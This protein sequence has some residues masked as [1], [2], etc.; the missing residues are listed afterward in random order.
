[1]MFLWH[2]ISFIVRKRGGKGEETKYLLQYL[3]ITLWCVCVCVCVCGG[4]GVYSGLIADEER[5]R[6]GFLEFFGSFRSL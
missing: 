2:M 4:G 3:T 6:L 5:E 1:M